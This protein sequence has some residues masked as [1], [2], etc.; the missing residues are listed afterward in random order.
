MTMLTIR[1]VDP[2]N[3]DDLAAAFEIFSD[4]DTVRW[5][6]NP[7]FSVWTDR[8]RAVAWAERVTALE[9]ADPI[10][11]ERAVVVNGAT[12]GFVAVARL[13]HLERGFE[14]QY[15]LGWKL[16]PSARG[17]GHTVPAARLRAREAFAAGVSELVIDMY[18]DNAPSAAVAR[19]L[20]AEELGVIPD[21]WYGG[22]SLQFRLTPALLAG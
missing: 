18:A 13:H 22:D 11:G 20:G 2:T 5:L 10:V 15:E 12:V 17:R 19:R 14:G 1:R 6:D 8:G 21:P 4:L 16:R 3:Q 7:P 9:A